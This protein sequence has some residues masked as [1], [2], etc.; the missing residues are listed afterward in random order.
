MAADYHPNVLIEEANIP[1]TFLRNTA[2]GVYY[3]VN[4]LVN[5]GYVYFYFE[6][7]YSMERQEYTSDDL[8]DVRLTAACIWKKSWI[9]LHL[10]I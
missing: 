3:T 7:N 5:G 8:T 6:R 1:V 4:K 9:A 10:K 2:D